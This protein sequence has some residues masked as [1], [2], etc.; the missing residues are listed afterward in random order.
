MKPITFHPQAEE[1]LRAAVAYYEEQ[2]EGLGMDLQA[3]IEGAVRRIQNNPQ[4]CPLYGE[5]GLR[6]CVVKRFPYNVFY[7]EL[8]ESIWIAAVAHQKRRPGYWAH[9]SP[10]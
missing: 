9:R 1:E 3:E 2:R 5:S 8:E 4:L 10:E 7:L 6:K